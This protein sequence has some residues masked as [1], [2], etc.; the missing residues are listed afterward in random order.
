M[1]VKSITSLLFSACLLPLLLASAISQAQDLQLQENR[2]ERY[3]VQ[4]GDTLWDIARRYL[5]SGFLYSSIFQDN[6]E[7]IRNPGV[8]KN[9]LGR[10]HPVIIE[11][12][13]RVLIRDLA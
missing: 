11:H 13:S 1:R 5:G 7:V 4:K 8:I 6:R 2:P 9:A 12:G 10:F 3:T